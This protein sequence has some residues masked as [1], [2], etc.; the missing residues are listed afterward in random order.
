M[1][2]HMCRYKILQLNESMIDIGHTDDAVI[3]VSIITALLDIST[4]TW[5]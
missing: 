1:H 2:V 4:T 3:G 5:N